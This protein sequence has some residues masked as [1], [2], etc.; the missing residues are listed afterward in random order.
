[1][2]CCAVLLQ[3]GKPAKD[4][5]ARWG[6]TP[7]CRDMCPDLKSTWELDFGDLLQDDAY[8]ALVSKHKAGKDQANGLHA[9]DNKWM[10]VFKEV[11]R[12]C[13]GFKTS[14]TV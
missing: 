6:T 12:V 1:M 8:R 14:K 5:L 10:T 7:S 3:D 2:L 4:D 11:G 9:E 13:S